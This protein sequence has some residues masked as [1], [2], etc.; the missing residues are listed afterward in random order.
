M[1]FNNGMQGRLQ[2]DA[3]FSRGIVVISRGDLGNSG[4]AG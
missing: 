3:G 1:I 2:F 4:K